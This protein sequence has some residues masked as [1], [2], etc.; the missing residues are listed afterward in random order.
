VRGFG[1][2]S[3]SSLEARRLTLHILSFARALVEDLISPEVLA[4]PQPLE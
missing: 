2:E 3:C 4:L 1:D